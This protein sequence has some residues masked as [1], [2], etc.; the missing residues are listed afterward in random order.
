MSDLHLLPVLAEN[1]G[2][3]ELLAQLHRQ[4]FESQGEAP[5]PATEFRQ[6]VVSPGVV[7][8]VASDGGAPVAFALWR[9]VLDE[10]ELI[11]IGTVP[12]ARNRGYARGLLGQIIDRLRAQGCAEFFLEVRADN[13][14][15]IKL[16]QGLGFKEIGK[17][18]RY[19][20]TQSGNLV[21]A[22]CLKLFV[23]NPT[24]PK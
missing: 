22:L 3:L 10:A 21:D 11:T 18:R 7:A 2:A 6:L 20:Q 23:N 16:Y 1:A 24:A 14:G 9:S 4:A 13:L 5:W 15:A 19:Y 17:R 8:I 12:A